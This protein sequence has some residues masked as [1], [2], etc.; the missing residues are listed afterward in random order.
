MRIT[1]KNCGGQ[2]P[3]YECKRTAKNTAP[4]RAGG[5][6]QVSPERGTVKSSAASRK[7][8]SAFSETVR[9]DKAAE[10][11]SGYTS[12]AGTQDLP[13][14]T[15]PLLSPIVAFAGEG[16]STLAGTV[17]D[18]DRQPK[19]DKAAWMRARMPEY[20]RQY[21]AE[22]KSGLRVPK[23]RTDVPS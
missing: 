2:H 7:D 12:L 6:D 10:P 4:V 20:M 22:V 9:T 11:L 15:Y 14:D 13:A 1:C 5:P 16:F 18:K 3:T 23:P 19:F 17:L 8:V 21:R